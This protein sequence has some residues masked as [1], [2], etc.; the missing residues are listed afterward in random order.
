ML[1]ISKLDSKQKRKLEKIV[2][3]MDEGDVAILEHLLELEETVDQKIDEIK[4]EIPSIKD[5]I[6]RVKGEAGYTPVKGTDYNDGYTPVKG[7]DYFDGEPGKDY[8]LTNKDKDEIAQKIEVPVVEKVVEKIIHE[9]P[10]VNETIK[11]ITVENPVTG[12]EVVEKI[13]SLEIEPDLQIGFEH[14]KDWKK[15]VKE[16]IRSFG[17]T[18]NLGGGITG[19][20]LFQDIDISSQFDG[21]LST[22]SIPAV[23]RIISVDLSSFP[24]GSCRKNVDY[25]WTPTSITFTS[26]IDPSTQLSAGQSCILTV[27]T[28]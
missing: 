14:I 8:I 24:Y 5:V 6:S 27:V 21:V 26:Q 12:K 15:H 19:R 25:T 10:V 16:E 9:Q 3:L 23:Y 22:F 17:G 4:A 28:G 11:N 13:N 7:E 2:K 1:D 20:D 18:N